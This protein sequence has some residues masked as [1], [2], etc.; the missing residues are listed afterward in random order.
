MELAASPR[1][2]ARPGSHRATVIANLLTPAREHP[3]LQQQRLE[4]RARLRLLL[5][6]RGESSFLLLSAL[7]FAVLMLFAFAGPLAT[8]LRRMVELGLQLP[9]LS[10]LVLGL[11]SGSRQR[12]TL[13]RF[14]L[15]TAQGW[16]AALPIAPA[17]QARARWQLRLRTALLQLLAG[18]LA[19]VVGVALGLVSAADAPQ[20]CI[21]LLLALALGLLSTLL[22][23]NNRRITHAPLLRS[24]VLGWTTPPRWAGPLPQL[25]LWQRRQAIR[26][27]RGGKAWVW[28]LPLGLLVLAGEGAQMLAGML[29]LVAVQPW[30]R[31]LLDASATALREATLLLTT[32][33]LRRDRF[34]A[35]GWRYPAS[36]AVLASV[37]VTVALAAMGAP[38]WL[39]LVG[40]GGFLLLCLLELALMLRYPLSR[41]RQ[42]AQLMAELALLI[43]LAQAGLGPAVLV[44]AAARIGWHVHQSRR[45]S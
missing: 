38:L 17:L 43:L 9:L 27:W 24:R 31:T 18:A 5:Q 35:S 8:G 39:L 11:L 10:V 21:G 20:V 29:I 41:G 15:D 40:G 23:P 30:L 16:L 7:V 4:L 3:R 19:V 44:I 33:P 2:E 45:P 14:E 32:T 25:P 12:R 36:R 28:L 34:V 13:H 37:L 6:R 26:N 42:R 1:F 22:I